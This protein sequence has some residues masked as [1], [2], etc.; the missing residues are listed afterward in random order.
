MLYT[1]N[2]LIF[3]LFRA[4]KNHENALDL[5]VLFSFPPPWRRCYCMVDAAEWSAAWPMP[6]LN[7]HTGTVPDAFAEWP[8][9]HGAGRL[10]ISL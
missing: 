10:A 3:K 1:I 5:F 8:H 4:K 2:F 7:G 6:L 9:R